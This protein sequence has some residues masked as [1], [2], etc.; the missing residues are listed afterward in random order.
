MTLELWIAFALSVAGFLLF[1]VRR[2]AVA[3]A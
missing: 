2:H 3:P 1:D